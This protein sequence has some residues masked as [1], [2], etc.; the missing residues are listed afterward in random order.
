[1][2]LF[3]K[4]KICEIIKRELLIIQTYFLNRFSSV[5]SS[6]FRFAMKTVNSRE[7]SI[8]KEIEILKK[9]SHPNVIK[10]EDRIFSSNES[11]NIYCLV[12]EYCQ[13]Y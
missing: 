4:W 6:P 7:N 3:T 10:L 11:P 8:V 13:V 9:L 5:L 12:I 1:M 2:G